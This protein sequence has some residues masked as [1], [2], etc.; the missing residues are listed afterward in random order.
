MPNL[1]YFD[2]VWAV[3]GDKTVIPDALDPG[4]LVSFDQGYTA[5]YGIPRG[6]PGALPIERDK[7]NYLMNQVTL[8]IQT[9]QQFGTPP[10]ITSSMNGGTPFP[11]AKY[12]RVLSGGVVYMSLID[13]NIDTP[14]TA[15]WSTGTEVN[16]GGTGRDTLTSY[17]ILIG[18]GTSSV[19]LLPPSPASGIPLVSQGS[20]AN[21]AYTTVEIAG[22]GTGATTAAGARANLGIAP[23]LSPYIS[24]AQTIT[25]AGA[26]TLS[27]GLG[28]APNF[29]TL[30]LVCTSA[31][32][33]YSPGDQLVYIG[34]G[35]DNVDCGISIVRDSS[36][37]Y[38]RYGATGGVFRIINKSNGVI[39][40]AAA[41]K[42]QAIF[43]ASL[44]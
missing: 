12:A 43:T 17:N 41:G 15:N 28:A 18:N 32:L 3:D 25:S 23:V 9:Y 20:S 31:D 21:P 42:W 2:T 11:Y 30:I 36:N 27:H 26:L 10:F 13:V 16:R 7:F 40:T 39:G 6:D 8:A 37:L 4:G 5:G 14:P 29:V 34:L 44:Y 38:I 24:S 35:G 22:G 1:N 19:S 33:G